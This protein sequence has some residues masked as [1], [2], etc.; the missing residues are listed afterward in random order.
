[1]YL[2]AEFRSGLTLSRFYRDRGTFQAKKEML[3]NAIGVEESRALLRC[4][5][6]KK[7]SYIRKSEH[8]HDTVKMHTDRI[9][10]V[11]GY[12]VQLQTVS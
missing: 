6:I 10:I 9:I 12:L 7:H 2:Q 3:C 11:N 5:S 4:Q 1:M 8:L